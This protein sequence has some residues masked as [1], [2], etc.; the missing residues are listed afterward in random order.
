[1]RFKGWLWLLAGLIVLNLLLMLFGRQWRFESIVM[2]HSAGRVGD[3]EAIRAMHEKRGWS[4]AAYHL[5]LSNGST[6]VPLGY[7]EPTNH[8][9]SLSISGATRDHRANLRSLQLCVVGDYE[10]GEF[11][12]ELR[13]ALAHALTALC[14]E[15]SIAPEHIVF[16]RD[17]GNTSCPGKHLIKDDLATWMQELANDCPE[18]IKAQHL[19]AIKTS[20]LTLSSYPTGLLML[21][22][23]ISLLLFVIFFGLARAFRRPTRH[24]RRVL[25]G[26]RCAATA[27]RLISRKKVRKN[28]HR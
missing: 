24:N 6:S 3:Y 13:P 14:E 21:Q 4:D 10:T 5:L 22:A 12:K 23:C 26:H 9:K 20:S 16:H 8:F 2:H 15:F 19:L 7:L 27:S 11:P 1:M 28:R 18:E 25:Q 17:L